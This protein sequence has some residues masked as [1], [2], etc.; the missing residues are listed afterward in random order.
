MVKA[1]AEIKNLVNRTLTSSSHSRSKQ[2]HERLSD[3]VERGV[4]LSILDLALSDT[5]YLSFIASSSYTHYNNFDKFRLLSDNEL[6][7]DLRLHIWWPG[8]HKTNKENIHDHRWDFSSVILKGEYSFELYETAGK[9]IEVYEYRY[10]NFA[11]AIPYSMPLIRKAKL[12]CVMLGK[13]KL[14]DAYTLK[15]NII[16]RVT[17]NTDDITAT[18]VLRGH[19]MKNHARVFTDLSNIN[20]HN[21]GSSAFSPASVSNKFKRLLLSL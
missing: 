14:G 6:A 15:H 3:L 11:G 16:H 10:S 8:S 19:T 9:G 1:I 5:D 20:M 2:R 18:L 17:C 13:K 7:Y 4:L 12:N 21:T